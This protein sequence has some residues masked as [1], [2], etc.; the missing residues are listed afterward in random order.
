MISQFV[1]T[2]CLYTGQKNK[3]LV[4][5]LIAGFVTVSILLPAGSKSQPLYFPPLTGTTWETISPDSLGWNTDR[6]DTL[7]DFLEANHTKAFIVLKDGRI[8]LEQYFGTFTSDSIWYWASAGKTLTAF[9]IGI[10]Q[11]EDLLSINDSTSNYL[12]S[13][14]TSC[15][16]EKEDLITIQNQ[17]TMTS[18]LRDLVSDPYCTSPE[19]LIYQTDAG[20][21]WAYHNAPYTLLDQVIEIVSGQTLNQ[22][23]LSKIRSK[24]GMNGLWI[25]S[26]YNNVYVSNARSMARFGLLALNRGIWNTD[27]LLTDISYFHDMTN[28]SQNL[29]PSYG[30]LWWLN[31]KASYM[32]PVLQTVFPGSWAANAPGDMFAALGKNGQFINIVPSQRL[33]MVRM[34][35]APDSSYEVPMEFNNDIWRKLNG[36]I[37]NQTTLKENNL[38]PQFELRQ[39]YP[40]PFNPA[41]II[42]YQLPT[43]S[44]VTLKI[45]DVLGREVRT[46]VSGRQNSGNYTLHFKAG[47]L[48]AGVYFYR[49]QSGSRHET[50]KL[51]IIK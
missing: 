18:G 30:Y 24:I 12:G 32:V 10:A 2:H 11:Q 49:L 42:Q 6:V 43:N 44:F 16:A 1:S 9:L 41:T 14:W 8:A 47:D 28:T 26:G 39:N 46:L 29:N 21:R 37:T 38:P 27:T 40:N 45:F 51:I 31:G 4:A 13:G 50:K 48:P 35:L 19:C 34:G 23:F 15:P 20:T 17:L 7:L 3:T 33:V 25:Q 22:Y 5:G 36:V